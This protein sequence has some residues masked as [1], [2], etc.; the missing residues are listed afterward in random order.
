MVFFF[1]LMHLK[2]TLRTYSPLLNRKIWI[3]Q[4][5]LTICGSY[6]FHSFVHLYNK[7]I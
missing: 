4:V 7:N 5:G 1:L 3:F 2:V 6:L